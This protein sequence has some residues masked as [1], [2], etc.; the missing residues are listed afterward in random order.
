MPFASSALFEILTVSLLMLSYSAGFSQVNLLKA[1]LQQQIECEQYVFPPGRLPEVRWKNPEVVQNELG[2]FSLDVSYYDSEMRRISHAEKPGRCAAV[3]EAHLPSGFTMRRFITLY[4]SSVEFDDYSENIPIKFNQLKNYGISESQWRLYGGRENRFAFGSMKM[5]PVHDPD[6]A[7]F[8][9][10]LSEIDSSASMTDTPR[11]RDRQWWITF[12]QTLYG[13]GK[14]PLQ[15]PRKEDG[16]NLPFITENSVLMPPFSQEHL[17]QI[18]SVC[19]DWAGETEVPHVALVVHKGKII[20]HEAFNTRTDKQPMNVE[21]PFS[22]ASITKLLTG[23]L[24]MQFVDQGLVELDSSVAK[25]LPELPA[26]AGTNLT[27]RHLFTHTTGL[28][29]WAGEWASD[30][31]PALENYIAQVLPAVTIGKKFSYNRVG[32]TIAGKIMERITG[33]AV[34]YLF[35]EYLFT[36]LGM[37]SAYADNTYGGLYCTAIDIARPRADAVE[38]GNV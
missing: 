30:W 3:I 7:V 24:M 27:V 5:F 10:G 14:T 8:L 31:N 34:P 17:E 12:K 20:F 37:K 33:R 35:H 23:V 9:A 29:D 21:A 32:Y 13:K 18:R 4:C 6:A 11:L 38:S 28:D 25:Y 26:T 2:R 36:P 1:F 19:R 16:T 22:M 15:L